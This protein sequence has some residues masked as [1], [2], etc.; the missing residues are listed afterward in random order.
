MK[1]PILS[2]WQKG[3]NTECR[4]CVHRHDVVFELCQT[5]SSERLVLHAASSSCWK[6]TLTPPTASSTSG[7]STASA[8]A[9]C[10]YIRWS[11]F[12]CIGVKLINGLISRWCNIWSCVDAINRCC[13]ILKSQK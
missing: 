3:L 9:P 10:W 13:L 4:R 6:L 2:R 12:Y 1:M 5:D 8:T 7:C 11:T